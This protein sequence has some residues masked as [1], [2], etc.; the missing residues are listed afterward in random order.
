LEDEANAA[1]IKKRHRFGTQKRVLRAKRI[2]GGEKPE[3]EDV[4]A[5]GKISHKSVDL[6]VQVLFQWD[7]DVPPISR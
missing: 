5:D 6:E 3:A 4:K 2:F 7:L 1:I